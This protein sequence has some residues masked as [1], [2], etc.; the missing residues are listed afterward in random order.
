[1]SAYEIMEVLSHE[2]E[3]IRP[4]EVSTRTS[5]SQPQVSRLVTQMVDAG[6]V[7]REPSPGDCRSSQIR[8]TAAG[9][10]IFAD[11]DATV[12]GVLSRITEENADARTWMT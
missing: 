1:M 3:W 6:Y 12:E 7:A 10:R 4:G 11:A 5:R 2:A 8:L 9:H